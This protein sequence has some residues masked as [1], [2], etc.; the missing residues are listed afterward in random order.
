MY[1][2]GRRLS[3][4]C[5]QPLQPLRLCSLAVLFQMLDGNS[6]GALDEA[7][8]VGG[9]KTVAGTTLGTDH[10]REVDTLHSQELVMPCCTT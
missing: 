5:L 4:P 2:H 6:S 7:K 3:S 10:L 8:L 9:L 1:V